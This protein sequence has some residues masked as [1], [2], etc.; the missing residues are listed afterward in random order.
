MSAAIN[1]N[2]DSG[3]T[4]FTDLLRQQ[5]YK[6]KN[7]ATEQGIHS[8]PVAVNLRNALSNF[9]TAAGKTVERN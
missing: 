1:T 4:K 3:S 7:V 8:T 5:L 9:D 2:Y 6:K